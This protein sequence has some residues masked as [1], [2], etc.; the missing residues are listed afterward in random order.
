MMTNSSRNFPRIHNILGTTT[1]APLD[2][3][4]NLDPLEAKQELESEV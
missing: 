3:P 1:G 4:R 2:F